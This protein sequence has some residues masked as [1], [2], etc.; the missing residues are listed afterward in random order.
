MVENSTIPVLCQTKM[1]L[2]LKG[3]MFNPFLLTVPKGV[4]QS[5][6]LLQTHSFY[7]CPTRGHSPLPLSILI[8][9]LTSPFVQA[10][11]TICSK[12]HHNNQPVLS[13]QRQQPQQRLKLLSKFRHHIVTVPNLSHEMSGEP[14]CL[15]WWKPI[16]SSI[17]WRPRPV[18]YFI[19]PEFIC[20]FSRISLKNSDVIDLS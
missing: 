17:F 20:L 3:F 8:I 16:P 15:A 7:P 5:H 6:F 18:S 10:K 13:S 9:L 11:F 14:A 2:I 12:I 4:L 1:I 19:A